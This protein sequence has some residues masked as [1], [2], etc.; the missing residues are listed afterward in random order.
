MFHIR[1]HLWQYIKLMIVFWLVTPDFGR[2]Y[3]VYNSLIRWMKPQV[4]TCWRKF[5]AESDNFLVNVERYV[6]ENGTEAL[7]KFITSKV[8]VNRDSK[9]MVTFIF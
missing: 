2:A 7:E 8:N 1:F 4:V 5:F 9:L 3:Y 6:K